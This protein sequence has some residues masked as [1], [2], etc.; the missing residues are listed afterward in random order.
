M[1]FS[2]WLLKIEGDSS[3]VIKATKTAEQHFKQLGQRIQAIDQR[4]QESARKTREEVFKRLTTEEKINKLLKDRQFILDRLNKTQSDKA[5]GGYLSKQSEIDRQIAELKGQQDGS[6]G[7]SDKATGI[8][9][10]LPV[11]AIAA[12]VGRNSKD[13]NRIGDKASTSGVSARDIQL[14]E[15][16]GKVTGVSGDDLFGSLVDLRKNQSK[17]LQGDESAIEN[18]ER[19]K[20]T[21]EDLSRMNAAGL[22]LKISDGVRSGAINTANFA[23]ATAV[24]GREFKQVFPALNEDL[25]SITSQFDFFGGRGEGMNE[26]LDFKKKFYSRAAAVPGQAASWF[27]NGLTE[28]FERLSNRFLSLFTMSFDPQGTQQMMAETEL[29]GD[30]DFDS[31]LALNRSLTDRLN[32]KKTSK[33]MTEK[34]K[35]D[36]FWNEVNEVFSNDYSDPSAKKEGRKSSRRSRGGS[37]LGRMDISDRARIG[38]FDGPASQQLSTL[39]EI[40]QVLERIEREASTE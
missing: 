8:L 12:L 30:E 40:K 27:G 14:S 11:G 19:L 25:R 7:L 21:I 31:G 1:S 5:R 9:S 22:F 20:I 37:D 18:F 23:S 36:A 15:F 6:G 34:A 28:G 24:L 13:A 39:K 10:L 4:N 26:S 2:K 32:Q 38:L 33:E 29:L 16:V 3:G 17:A 35:E